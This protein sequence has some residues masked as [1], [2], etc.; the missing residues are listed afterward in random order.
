MREF[1][2]VL[3]A[4]IDEALRLANKLAAGRGLGDM[5]LRHRPPQHHEG[6]GVKDPV[7]GN[8]AA[9]AEQHGRHARPPAPPPQGAGD[10]DGAAA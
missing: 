1:D 4:D 10:V 8:K 6:G 5:A 2:A 3:A 7:V 9:R